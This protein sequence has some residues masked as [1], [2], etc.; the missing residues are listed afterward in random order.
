MLPTQNGSLRSRKKRRVAVPR[1]DGEKSTLD[2]TVEDTSAWKESEATC[3]RRNLRRQVRQTSGSH[4]ASSSSSNGVR[5]K[6]THDERGYRT[7]GDKTK[8][9]NRTGSKISK[10]RQAPSASVNHQSVVPRRS[11]R[12][13]QQ[14]T[15]RPDM[16][17]VTGRRA[18]EAASQF[19]IQNENIP[20]QQPPDV[21]GRLGRFGRRQPLVHVRPGYARD[22]MATEEQKAV[23]EEEEQTAVAQAERRQANRA[24][25]NQSRQPG[26]SSQHPSQSVDRNNLAGIHRFNHENIQDIA[27]GIKHIML[28]REQH[29]LPSVRYLEGQDFGPDM[30]TKVTMRAKL[31]DWMGE[32][33]HVFKLSRAT[34][35]HAYSYVDRFL[36]RT[37]VTRRNLQ[38][39]GATALW[40]ASKNMDTISI[41]ANHISVSTD[42]SCTVRDMRSMEMRMVFVLKWVLD[43]ITV[44][45][46]V[47]MHLSKVLKF[48]DSYKSDYR[49]YDGL[50]AG[51]TGLEQVRL[52][53]YH[54]ERKSWPGI[55]IRDRNVNANP[56]KLW[57]TPFEVKF[58]IHSRVMEIVDCAML[59]INALDFL[60]SMI[61]ATAIFHVLCEQFEL[62][63]EAELCQITEYNVEELITCRHWIDK[64][65]TLVPKASNEHYDEYLDTIQRTVPQ[66]DW[67]RQHVHNPYSFELFQQIAKEQ[68]EEWREPPADEFSELDVSFVDASY[69]TDG[70][71][72]SY[73][74]T[75]TEELHSSTVSD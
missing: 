74:V 1:A 55:N 60:P 54:F 50:E 61:A 45:A 8:S 24:T 20:P 18:R 71:M 56:S 40:T 75:S 13:Q 31:F 12:L 22:E 67:I 47:D 5:Q 14:Q 33:C 15:T 57:L 62:V 11:N 59:D 37:H 66:S 72:A 73:E 7:Q 46:W 36:T 39:V 25:A 64:F 69:A 28:F 26:S 48:L 6:D 70:E 58:V 51:K 21:S 19:E 32:V 27:N 43:P 44:D 34:L 38:L 52:V 65:L 3:D 23:E 41:P 29:N 68:Q 4:Y 63:T 16:D 9:V 17:R 2:F 53:K 10:T 30:H 35:Y 42:G 49:L